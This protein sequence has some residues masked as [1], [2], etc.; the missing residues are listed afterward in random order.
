[1]LY[2]ALGATEKKK[3]PLTVKLGFALAGL[4][5]GFLL[6]RI[7]FTTA[8]VSDTT[9]QP[10]LQPGQRVLVYRFA[11]IE[12]GDIVLFRSAAQDND[13][14]LKRVAGLPGEAVS[15]K[16][17][18]LLING[19]PL[20]I[21]WKQQISDARLFSEP[22]SR[23]DSLKEITVAGEHYFM[24]NDNLDQAFDSREFGPVA[25]D[26]IAGVVVYVF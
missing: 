22:F 9:M 16:E 17:R 13:T 4:A 21:S 18:T 1:M 25:E 19:K 2:A 24:L 10:G 14:F 23:R 7:F 5:A 20:T 15:V 6:T 3:T 11:G 12:R 8:V 26:A